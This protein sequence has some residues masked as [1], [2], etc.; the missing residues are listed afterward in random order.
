MRTKSY[1]DYLSDR[2]VANHRGI[3]EDLIVKVDNDY[4]QSASSDTANSNDF[5]SSSETL[6]EPLIGLSFIPPHRP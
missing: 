6:D 5:V 3:I 2:S 4:E 1:I